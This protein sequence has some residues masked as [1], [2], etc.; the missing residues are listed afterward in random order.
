MGGKE[1]LPSHE[2]YVELATI[3]AETFVL[4]WDLHAKQLEDG[5]YISVKEPL[6]HAHLEAHL[7]GDLTLGTYLLDAESKGRFLVFDADNEPDWRRLKALT[8][9]LADLETAS[10]LERSRRGG[11]LWLF[12]D[13]LQQGSVI[14]QFGT[15][16]LTHFGIKAIE[17]F[18]KQKRLRTGPGSLVRLPFGIH[19]KTGRRY[20]IYGA[21]GDPL[22]PSLSEQITRLGARQTV[23]E[24][25]LT[26]FAETGS[27]GRL[28]R[29]K[30]PAV[31]PMETKIEVADDA[32]LSEGVKAAITVRQLVLRYVELS[33]QGRGHCPFHDDKNPSFSI[34]DDENYWYCFACK[35]G[36]SVID[37]WMALKDCDYRTAVR[38]LVPQIHR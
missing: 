9:V 20:G 2:R 17:M 15:G 18:P 33:P 23:P 38:E 36:G 25:V 4:R 32:P 22:A 27:I 5:S 7:R 1:Q 14:R 29:R 26:Q 6:T 24:P 35:K 12:F 28:Q 21:L 11:H 8:Q 13:Q 3:L 30:E 16:L 10:H 19:Q 34:N 37:F 31:R